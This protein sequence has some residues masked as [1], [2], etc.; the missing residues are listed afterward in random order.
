MTSATGSRKRLRPCLLVISC[1][2]TLAGETVAAPPVAHELAGARYNDVRWVHSHNSYS[3]EGGKPDIEE[4][5]RRGVRSF[6]FD[7]HRKGAA[8]D[9]WAVYHGP[10][11]FRWFSAGAH[12]D[13]LKAC[14]GKIMAWHSR[15]H[16]VVTL[17]LEI[18]D[19]WVD[20]HQPADLDLILRSHLQDKQEQSLIYGPRDM[21]KDCPG[22][23]NLQQAV[24][25]GCGWPLMKDL[26]GKFII[27]LHGKTHKLKR[28]LSDVNHYRRKPGQ[29]PPPVGL[30]FV[31]PEIERVDQIG[32]WSRGFIYDRDA[33]FYNLES[34]SSDVAPHLW[35]RGFVSRAYRADTQAE[36]NRFRAHSVHHMA[37]DHIAF[38]RADEPLRDSTAACVERFPDIPP[39]PRGRDRPRSDGQSANPLRP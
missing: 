1:C 25:D 11:P 32:I 12:C 5:A 24:T 9:D 8:T 33:V 2:F 10:S 3:H 29:S 21:L 26:K 6:E 17:W 20:G 27:V 37:T 28:Y 34:S 16:A 39:V 14:L 30:C 13:G 22:A 38:C 15:E 7:L 31:A 19:G 35:K 36:W 23:W 18:Y 4:Q